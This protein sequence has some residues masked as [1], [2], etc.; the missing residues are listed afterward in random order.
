MLDNNLQAQLKAYLERLTKPVELV[1]NIDDSQKSNEIKQLLE[2]IASLSDKVSVREERN[3]AIRTP[4]FLITNPGIDSGLRF[5]GSPLGHEFTSLVLA[6][7]QIG[8][9]P[10]KEAQELLEQVKGLEGEFHFETYYSLSCH[11][12]PD[13]VQALNLMAVLNPNVSHT[14]IDGALF[15]NEID[16]RNVMGVPAVFLNGK[17][18]GQGRMTL[19]EIVSK[20]DTNSDARAAKS[21]T[22]RKPFE[23]LVIGSGPAGASAAIYTARKGIRTGVIGERFGGQVMDTVDIE[24]Y[25]SVIKTEGAIFAGALKNHVDSYDVD[26]IDGQSVAK[27]IPAAEDGGLHQIETASGGIL[28]SRSIIISTGARWRNMGVPGEQE[29]RTKGVTFCP[30]CDGPLFKGKRVA[31]I[32]GGNSGIEAAIDLA[33]VV[34]HVTVL[35]FAP[36]LK[37]DSVLQEKVRSLSNVDIILNAQ[38]LEVKGDGSKMTGLEYKDRTDDSVHLLEVA[39]AFVQIGLLPNTNWLGD[40]IAR[41]RMGE[42]EIDARN[43]TSVKGIFAAGD[44]TTVPYKQIIISAGEGAKAALSAFDYL[45]RTSTRTAE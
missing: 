12:C 22:E 35:E 4:S 24:N 21:L 10:S 29:Y 25:I 6:L 8:G 45:I 17:E 39:G 18:F 5:A 13:V 23:V 32:G 43:E 1:A 11:N 36:E 3:D 28:K 26:V 19:S 33:G 41:N 27:L 9:H 34:D 44:C 16:E 2:Q 42:I 38:T 15:Q 7:L 30:H 14:A 20:V 40:T 31:V 37:A